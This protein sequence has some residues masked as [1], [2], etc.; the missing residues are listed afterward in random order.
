VIIATISGKGFTQE[1]YQ[2]LRQRVAWEIEPV[3][4]WIVHTARWDDSG[5]IHMTNIWESFEHMQ[6]GFATRL[7]PIMR[8]IGIPPPHVEVHPTF[9]VNVF[10]NPD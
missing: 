1:M 3:D 9:N 6:N 2:M 10:V 5:A 7:G 4:G 8:S